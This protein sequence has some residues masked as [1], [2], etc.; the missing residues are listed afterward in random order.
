MVN[1]VTIYSPWIIYFKQMQTLFKRDPEIHLDFNNDNATIDMYVD[2]AE[3]YEALDHLLPKTKTFGNVTVKINIIPAN[4]LQEKD[5][6]KY[7]EAAF[8]G[9][10]AFSHFRTVDMKDVYMSNPISYCVFKKEIAQYGADDLS[11]EFGVRSI[12][13]EDLARELLPDI[14]GV[15]FCTDVK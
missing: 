9:N 1:K 7:I 2:S 4:S 12:L 5:K 13:Y 14:D 3:K 15:F 10:G 8:R 11:S 6:A